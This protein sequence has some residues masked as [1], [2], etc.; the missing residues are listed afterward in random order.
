MNE[1]EITYSVVKTRKGHDTILVRSG[2]REIYLH[3]RVSP[4]REAGLFTGRFDPAHFDVLI[5][6]GCGLGYHLLPLREML[7]RYSEVIIIDAIP[8]IEK[9]IGLNGLT[10][11][12]AGSRRVTILSGKTTDDVARILSSRIDMDR[13]R[14]ISVLEHPASVRAF[15]GYYDRIRKEVEKLIRIKAGNRVTREAFGP[16]FVANILRNVRH[17]EEARPVRGL[18]GAFSGR[19]AV[20]VVSGPS[21]EEDIG[22]IQKAQ[23]RFFIVAVDSALPVLCRCGIAPDLVV[24]VD[25]QP[26]VREHFIRCHTGSAPVVC[27][28]SSHP[29]VLERAR[30]FVSLNSHPLAQ[31]AAEVYGDAVGSVDSST[32]S[33]AGDA[34]SLCR[35]CGF[36]AIGVTGLD[37]SFSGYRI[38]AR[39]TAY[40]DRYA[41]FFQDRV[42]TVEGLNCRYI[43]GSSGGLK[44]EGKFTRKSFLQYRQSIEDYIL[45]NSIDIAILNDRGL[46]PA[47]ARHLNFESFIGQHCSGDIPKKDII[48]AVQESSRPI[49]A[50]PLATALRNIMHEKLFDEL[51]DASLGDGVS[52]RLK[53]KYR[54]LVD[55]GWRA[56]GE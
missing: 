4:E 5:A 34:I 35:A 42:T 17:L 12:L 1:I 36:S 29:S 52:N 2:D 37:F 53:S 26:Y 43:L 54:G 32:G 10:S 38:Y 23:Q 46:P 11:F 6:L 21:L 49:G 50:G 33:V 16:R 55:R 25:P 44:R 39:G 47:G 19:P 48:G 3:S 7:D 40:Q 22:L 31:L 45:K 41:S 15:E 20:I 28:I 27:S 18:F 56:P 8:G 24:S 14:G 30:V 9:E 51:L 13:I